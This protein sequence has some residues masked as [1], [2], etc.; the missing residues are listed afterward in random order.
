MAI[1]RGTYKKTTPNG[2]DA[3][4]SIT[5]PDGRVHRRR[6]HAGHM[7]DVQ[8][9]T[10]LTSPNTMLQGNDSLPAWHDSSSSE[11][12]SSKYDP[13]YMRQQKAGHNKGNDCPIRAAHTA[14]M[15]A[16]KVTRPTPQHW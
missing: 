4:H 12:D 16:M 3:L 14:H 1:D 5:L 6:N 2:R 10:L 8:G 9:Q 15:K 7:A 11:F 13:E